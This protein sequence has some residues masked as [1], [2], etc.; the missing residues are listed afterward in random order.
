MEKLFFYDLE[1]TGLD[2]KLN[3]IHQ[4]SAII[5]IDGE[6]KEKFNF[7]V[8]PSD[9]A[10]IDEYALKV[11]GVTT[12]QILSYPDMG[13]VYKQLIGVLSKYVDKFNKKD[14][15]H[16][17]GYNICGFDNDF[18]RNFFSDNGDKYFGS[19]FF[20]GGID[21]MVLANHKLRKERSLIPDFKQSTVAKYMGI[22]IDESRLHDA[23][24]DIEICMKIYEKI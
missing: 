5:V 16:L 22:E 14:K 9:N 4:I 7:K 8:R 23:E 13:L 3:G 19:W 6:I 11:A 10:I 1:T 24:Y 2:S 17:V 15:F 21:C 12:E 18:F 20:S